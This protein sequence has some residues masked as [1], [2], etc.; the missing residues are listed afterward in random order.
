M[1]ARSFLSLRTADLLWV[2]VCLLVLFPCLYYPYSTLSP[3]LGFSLSSADWKVI[4][5][6]PCPA[7]PGQC[8][9]LDDQLLSIGGVTFE[10]YSKDRTIRM[11][12]GADARGVAH[13]RLIRDGREME[14]DL[15]FSM[16]LKDRPQLV[17]MTLFPLIFWLMGTITVIFLRPRDER[18]LALVL[19]SY[20]TALWIASGW[21]S[22]VRTGGAGI[23]FHIVI[24]L[25]LPFSAHLHAILPSPLPSRRPA[26]LVLLSLLYGLSF[27]LI[28]LDY[29]GKLDKI[30]YSYVWSTLAGLLLSL[31]L[32]L[33]RLLPGVD[34]AVKIAARIMLFGVLLG[35]GP[36]LVVH[37]MMPLFLYLTPFPVREI[38]SLYPWMQGISLLSMPILPMSYIYAIYKH[39]LGALEFRA[40]RLLGV[41][42]FS[43]LH[44]TAYVIA[45]FAISRY[46]FP[47]NES[48]LA[49]ILF[50]SL[51]FIASTP[52]L[53]NR[54]QRLVDRYVFG[55]KHEPEEVIAIVSDR[56]PTAF[57]R[58]VLARV[59][60]EDILPTLLIR[61]SAL[62]L[63]EEGDQE[64]L[65]EQGVPAQETE[66]TLDELRSMLARK[67]RYLTPKD[68]TPG[69]FSWVRLVIPLV[70]QGRTIG[71]WLIG[72]RDPDDYFP[73]ADINLISTVANQIAPVVE[74][75]RLYEKAQQEI[76]Q[77]KA[78]EEEIRRSE[79]RFR[80]LFEATLEGIA[81]VKNGA[82]LEVNHALLA[83]FDRPPGE[84]LGR[85]L[86]DL[87]SE[88]EAE[89]DDVPRECLGWKQDGSAV[90]IEVAGKKY[91]FQG[92]DVTVV[93]I[94]DIAQ[95][96]RD[97]AEN[98]MLQRQLLHSQ[99]M[100]AI[101]RLSAGVAH[102]FNNCLLAIFGY[103]DLLIDR[104][105]D[106]TFLGRNLSGI[107]EAGQKA[108]A[109]TKQLL[110]FARRQPMETK[111]MNLNSVVS[112]LEKMLQRLLGEDVA[113]VTELHP[114][115]GP[116][117]VDPG[118]IEQVIVNLAV[119]ARYA[120]PSGGRL[121]IKTVPLLVRDGSPAPHADVPA[122]SYVLLT[123]ADTGF[124]MTAETLA[125]VFEPFFSTKS[126]GTGLGL[127]TAYGIVRQS[128]GHI[129]VD[130]APGQGACFA[131][132]L[133]VTRETDSGRP[134]LAG[135][136]ADVGSET[137]LLV[138]DEDEVRRVLN[139]ILASKGYRVLQASS[140]EEA[141]V[142]S[143]LHR[144]AIDLLLTDVTMPQMK[145]P[146]LAAR[147]LSERRETRVVYMSGYN[148]ELLSDGE[149][150][151]PICLNKPFSSQTLGRTV[152]EVLDTP[153]EERE[154]LKATG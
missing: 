28:G 52:V 111:V 112:G 32:L 99:K 139:Q 10:E 141:L 17:L 83:I 24:W 73:A 77:R 98:K 18:W 68:Q 145:G 61:Q 143:R 151:P 12:D 89:I 94:R 54:F 80:T 123:V 57:D 19:F 39:Y 7:T 135:G 64:T 69:R 35:L 132:Y 102:D 74:N 34:P 2:S 43:A 15:R 100:E 30:G 13:V 23:V 5:A 131:I 109:L 130:S 149:S 65:F 92:E 88:N 75:I 41:Y 84:I 37:G 25:F 33:S 6:E 9:Q 36:F 103:S 148:E 125:R 21:A 121:S 153:R 42:S 110:A 150:E 154:P 117:K 3:N 62:Y 114:E 47:V 31:C 55:L 152:R 133:P 101:G 122:G 45:L 137:I 70:L 134:G 129:F 116:V 60:S 38:R 56:I 46:W 58:T 48:Y 4:S 108:A 126:E 115:L 119:N 63:F 104:Y 67:G 91:V 81:I 147:L 16:E 127:S 66:P 59:I 96:K 44:I 53:R 85:R 93:A 146:E 95:R 140:G 72:R 107:K 40:N 76:A 14:L 120:M 79:E 82:V 50:L 142:I 27:V 128:G 106:D 87:I 51:A 20:G 144:G 136:I 105:K 138:E 8:L 29:F 49:A 22:P 11:L 124:G 118:Q 26:R 86:S 1:K 90:D 78:A 71:V 113:L 97:E